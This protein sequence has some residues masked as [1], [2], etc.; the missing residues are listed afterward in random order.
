MSNLFFV[1][2]TY[3]RFC[4]IQ[5]DI[6]F[7]HY[8][9]GKNRGKE[10]PKEL[11]LFLSKNNLPCSRIFLLEFR[12]ILMN[13]DL[14]NF[15]FCLFV[16]YQKESKNSK[17]GHNPK[18]HDLWTLTVFPDKSVIP[19]CLCSQTTTSY[20]LGI[21]FV[22][23]AAPKIVHIETQTPTWVMGSFLQKKKKIFVH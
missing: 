22:I 11:T 7:L 12:I 20:T 21:C 14:T 18:G 9:R 3:S 4:Y 15:F 6:W 8:S 1:I 23:P 17:R 5:D 10:R 2:L 19:L 13:R 16:Y